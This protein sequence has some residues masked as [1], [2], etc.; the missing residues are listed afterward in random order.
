MKYREKEK[1]TQQ[2]TTDNDEEEW[3]FILNSISIF[4]LFVIFG[5]HFLYI[6]SVSCSAH[7][8]QIAAAC[9]NKQA[10]YR[11]NEPTSITS[12]VDCAIH[13]WRGCCCCCCCYQMQLTYT[14]M[15]CAWSALHPYICWYAHGISLSLYPI[16]SHQLGPLQKC[17]SCSM[18]MLNLCTNREIRECWWHGISK[19]AISVS[20]LI[21]TPIF[22]TFS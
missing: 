6:H 12:N 11:E 16:Q 15:V 19:L 4:F 5:L 20:A 14:A 22:Q 3:D 17:D 8:I 1:R 21:Y 9:R 10:D 2:P 7:K 18:I 13:I